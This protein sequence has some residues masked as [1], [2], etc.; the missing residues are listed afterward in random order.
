MPPMDACNPIAEFDEREALACAVKSGRIAA[1][2]FA[3]GD[4]DEAGF[5]LYGRLERLCEQGLLR[6]E[7]WSGDPAVGRGD[8]LAV[9]RPEPAAYAHAA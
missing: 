6:F 4:F 9:F 3:A 5:L 2:L 1:R 8:V 7:S